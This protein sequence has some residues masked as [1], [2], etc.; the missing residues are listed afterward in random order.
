VLV[1]NLQGI[2][3]A[4]YDARLYEL[5]THEITSLIESLFVESAKRDSAVAEIRSI[6]ETQL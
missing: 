1:S 3:N 5:E 2:L 6:R 4:F